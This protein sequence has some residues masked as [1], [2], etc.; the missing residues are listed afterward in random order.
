MTYLWLKSANKAALATLAAILLPASI[1]A[2]DQ[3]D[4]DPSGSDER[5]ASAAIDTVEMRREPNCAGENCP[6]RIVS[7]TQF[8]VNSDDA[9]WQV[10]I[11]SYLHTDYTAADFAEIPE[12][13]R[14]H[15][16]GGTLIHRQ[17]V[18]TAAHCLNSARL[19]RSFDLRVRIG[20]DDL[21]KMNGCLYK[22]ADRIPHPEYNDDTLEN[23]IALLRIIIPARG[24]CSRP[25]KQVTLFTKPEVLAVGSSLTA[26]GWGKTKE[27]ETGRSSAA[28]LGARLAYVSL[29]ACNTRFPGRINETNVCAYKPETDTCKGDSGG[30][31]LLGVPGSAKIQ[32]GVVSW[33][34]G[35]ARRGWPGVYTHVGHYIDWIE[36][37]AQIS[38]R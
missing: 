16:C 9:P 33:G 25:S 11:Q 38:I 12:W 31:L 30:P 32:V 21:A 8:L 4:I 27:G 7:P 26:Y 17:W 2:Q 1:Q 18:L 13:E 19:E 5:D 37:T 34:R 35:C 14:R 36:E 22:V 3:Q 10:S 6:S 29:P 23:D 15:K 28:L 24:A 20:T